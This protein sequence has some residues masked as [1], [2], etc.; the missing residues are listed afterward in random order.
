V[1]LLNLCRFHEACEIVQVTFIVYVASRENK[2][3]KGEW[4]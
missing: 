2:K 3:R 4:Y 1:F